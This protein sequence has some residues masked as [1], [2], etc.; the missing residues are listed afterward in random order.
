MPRK[1]QDSHADISPDRNGI[2]TLHMT[3]T[4]VSHKGYL[5]RPY[6]E[7]PHIHC[8]AFSNGSK[9]ACNYKQQ[10]NELCQGTMW[11]L[12][13]LKAQHYDDP[14]KQMVLF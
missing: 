4:P 14:T 9:F 11:C 3:F 6:S 8:L 5:P 2:E 13:Q 1:Q 7:L 12:C 10:T